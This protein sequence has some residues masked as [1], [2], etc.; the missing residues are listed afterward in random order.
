MPAKKLFKGLSSIYKYMKNDF[1]PREQVVKNL[2]A[3]W[4]DKPGAE[5][6]LEMLINEEPKKIA[7]K[8]GKKKK[9]I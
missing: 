6:I 1:L 3:F 7:K 2:I 5:D 8:K 9:G 4:R